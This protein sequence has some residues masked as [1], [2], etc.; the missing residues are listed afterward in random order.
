MGVRGRFA[1]LELDWLSQSLAPG[2]AQYPRRQL[3]PVLLFVM[4]A[5]LWR[6]EEE[7]PLSRAVATSLFLRAGS[8][9]AFEAPDATEEPDTFTYDPGDPV[10][11]LGGAL[12]MSN[13]FR[14]GPLDQA[15]VEARADVMVYTTEP[16]TDD[17]EVTGRIQANLIVATDAPST[18]WVIRICDVDTDGVSWNIVDGIVRAT[19]LP[20]EFSEQLVDLWSTSYV[21]RAGH[22][23]RAQVTSSNFPRWD[24]NFN[25]GEPIEE[26][27]RVQLARQQI[28]HEATRLSR[29][30]LPVIPVA[31]GTSNFGGGQASRG[32]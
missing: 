1:D 3:P 6:E 20:G 10:A 32:S 31:K 28:A 29:I 18:D 27:T 17:L 23:I 25:T 26:R 4:G 15:L 12:S 11:T 7:W 8:R 21:F 24:R 16:L 13:E 9:L 30:V 5:N 22:C 19:A 14:P 2:V